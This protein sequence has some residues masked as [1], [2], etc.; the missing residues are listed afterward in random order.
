MEYVPKKE[1]KPHKETFTEI[2]KEIRPKIKNEGVTFTCR[3][4]GSAKRNLVVR[5]HNK[6]F[7]C[8]YQIIIQKNKNEFDEESMKKLFIREFDHSVVKRGFKNCED[9][10]QAITIKKVDYEN[11]KV[12]KAY[13][14]VILDQ[15]DDGIYILTYHKKEEEYYD[16]LPL[17]DT[18]KHSE[19]FKKIKGAEMWNYLRDIY[20]KKKE[21]NTED[22]K[23]FQIFNEAVNETLQKFKIVI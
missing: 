6:G 11:S 8:D 16:Y 22:K 21:D 7:D 23:S 20:L 9:S 17:P 3:L 10:K 15:R 5:H 4:V 19:N 12:L 14:V 13:D 1:V 18:F 2:I